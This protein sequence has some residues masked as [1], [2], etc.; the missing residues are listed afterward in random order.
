MWEPCPPFYLHL[1][2][3][4]LRIWRLFDEGPRM[5]FAAFR[6]LRNA[7]TMQIS[8]A[9]NSNVILIYFEANLANK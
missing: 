6:H 5:L 1:L 8:F 2:S 4:W 7:G 9:D 3:Q